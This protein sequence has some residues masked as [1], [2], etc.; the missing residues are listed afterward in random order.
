MN[1]LLCRF[2]GIGDE[3]ILSVVAKELKRERKCT[4]DYAVQ[5]SHV[6]LFD[7]L[8]CF[9][10]VLPTRRLFGIDCVPD[11]EHWKAIDAIKPEYDWVIDYKFS[12][13]RNT[14]YS[15]LPPD[16]PYGPWTTSMN[17]NYVNWIDLS[18]AWANIDPTKVEDKCPVYRVREEE[19]EWAIEQIRGS[20]LKIVGVHVES[21]SLSR[22]WYHPEILPTRIIDTFPKVT[23][24][25][26]MGGGQWF[27]V[28]KGGQKEIQAP[29]IR[30]SFALVERM[31]LLVTADS[32]FSHIAEA[33]GT[34]HV[35]IYTTVPA[36][37][38]DKYYRYSYPV[39]PDLS[40][41]PC[42]NL[43]RF[44][45]ENRRRAKESLNERERSILED[46]PTPQ[47]DWNELSKKYETTMEGLRNERNA[48][49]QKIQGL[50]AVIPPCVKAV[51]P[52][53]ILERIKEIL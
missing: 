1:V 25:I 2:G 33:L 36:W 8:D 14:I 28:K 4:I 38:R 37:T 17:S 44:C 47:V 12:I 40:C 32:G 9:D 53:M 24:L 46:I 51:T 45:P 20:S 50:S 5:E 30:H 21:S 41:R 19:R 39:E 29:S 49:E 15:K 26:H 43:D 18:L 16:P 7:N 31:N 42:F 13:E 27:I 23:V 10:S 11:G 22:T 3:L 52:E 35:T 6:S 34:R 48:I